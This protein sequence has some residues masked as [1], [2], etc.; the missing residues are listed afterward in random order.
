MQVPILIE[1]THDGRFRAHV[2]EPFE[3]AAEADNPQR[4]VDNLVALV[5]QRLRA[6]AKVASLTVANGTVRAS[7]SFP[8][9]DAYKTDWVYRELEEAIAENRRL[10][11][12]VAP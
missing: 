10:E 5:E 11:D 8:A 6:G 7:V 3:V 1:P 9:D 2:G 4:A 12:T